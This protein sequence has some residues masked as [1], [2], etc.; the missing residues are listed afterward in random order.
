[1]PLFPARP[2]APPAPAPVT[3][4]AAVPRH[5]RHILVSC[6]FGPKS[7]TVYPAIANRDCIFFS[8]NPSLAD[9]ARSKGWTFRIVPGQELSDDIR[10]SSQQSKYIKFL[11]FLKAYP[12]FGGVEEL[13]YFD[14]K[15]FVKEEHVQWIS[16][17]FEPGK[18]VLIRNTPMLK[19]RIADEV[20]AAMGQERYATNMPQTLRW[21][22]Q[23]AKTH[24]IS[25]NVRIV[26]TGLIH[27][28]NFAA[29]M[30]ML[31]EI[32][33]AVWDLGQP[34]CQILWAALAQ[35]HESLIQRVEWAQLCPQWQAP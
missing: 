34:E 13:T 21:L 19:A 27:Y 5:D 22:E 35:K 17:N 31:D 24:G 23:M 10:I 12:E 11:Q 33:R 26:N 28:R 14:H 25:N 29:V 6:F 20:A 8:N 9:E 16:A 3:L 7:S 18:S 2:A 32:H 30:P 1:V 15:F 4:P